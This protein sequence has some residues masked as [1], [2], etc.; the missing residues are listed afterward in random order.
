MIK[1]L[2]R[3]ILPRSIAYQLASWLRAWRLR[4]FPRRV[5][6]RQYAGYDLQVVIADAMAEGW[7]DR[8]WGPKEMAE[9]E[10]LR[11]GRLRLGARVFDLGAH[12]AIVA[13][14]LA[15]E[16]GPSGTVIA[17]EA[18]AWNAERARENT[19]VNATS[20]L[21]VLHGV[22]GDNSLAAHRSLG[23]MDRVYEWGRQNVRTLTIDDLTKQYGPP[24]VVY[25]DVDGF[26]LLALRGASQTLDHPADW[27]VEVH[28]GEGLENEGGTWE[29]VLEFFSPVR[30]TR[31][32]GSDDCPNF[33]PFDPHAALLARRF[34][35]VALHR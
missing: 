17:V 28:V 24:D 2:L 9:L 34:F 10:V 27:F 19:E 25:M 15:R 31:M 30:F 21:Q 7:Y 33:E 13:N 14:I 1:N 26:E 5:V 29:Q 16:V 35:L 32:I 23:E 3:K 22:I 4:T 11:A 20:N 6:L 8:A 12:Q 18:D